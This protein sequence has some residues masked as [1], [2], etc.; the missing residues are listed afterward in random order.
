MVPVCDGACDCASPS[1]ACILVHVALG[2]ANQTPPPIHGL[3]DL[4]QSRQCILSIQETLRPLPLLLQPH[5]AC[6]LVNHEILALGLCTDIP[7]M[8][9][10]TTSLV[11]AI[12]RF[13][14]SGCCTCTGVTA[15]TDLDN[16]STVSLFSSS[17][18]TSHPKTTLLQTTMYASSNLP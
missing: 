1:H 14:A 11:P 3:L 8:P 10:H 15:T 9:F 6:R 2:G 13:G 7:P 4:V 5:Q 16:P 17:L 12:A 18:I